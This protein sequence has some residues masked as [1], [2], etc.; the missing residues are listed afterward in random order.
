MSIKT[1]FE[2][3]K[4]KH[5]GETEHF[6]LMRD[7]FPVSLGHTLIITKELQKDYF[8][9]THAEKTDLD[10]AIML[11]KSLVELVFSPDDKHR[12]ELRRNHRP[13]YYQS[14]RQDKRKKTYISTNTL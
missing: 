6:F 11:A 7:G 1:F 4:E 14:N 9:L 10:N 8:E 2:L 5:I 12:H 13:D 3:P